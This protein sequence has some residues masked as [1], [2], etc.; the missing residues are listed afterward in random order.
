MWIAR[1]KDGMLHVFDVKPILNHT[2]LRWCVMNCDF[3]YRIHNNT[4]KDKF[5][6]LTFE[7]SP[8]EVDLTLSMNNFL[9][10]KEE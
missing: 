6:D 8:I 9:N 10:N 2:G 4:D 3:G 5:M 1:N 7:D